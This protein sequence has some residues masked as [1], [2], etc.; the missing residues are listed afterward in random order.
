MKRRRRRRGAEGPE[1]RAKDVGC[2][3]G[4]TGLQDSIEELQQT[5]ATQWY[6]LLPVRALRG[7]AHPKHPSALRILGTASR[8]TRLR[9][10]R[11]EQ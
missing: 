8:G 3:C 6:T 4:R 1:R 7:A 10:G 5:Q 11:A 2:S 9:F